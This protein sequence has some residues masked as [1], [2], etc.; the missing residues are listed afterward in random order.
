MP[1]KRMRMYRSCL[2]IVALLGLLP[3]ALPAAEPPSPAATE[4]FE[5]DIRPLLVS[6]CHEC[7]GD[8]KVKGGLHITSRAKLLEGG[9]TGPALVPGKPDESLLI[10]AVRYPSDGLKMPPKGKLPDADIAKLTRWVEM[11]APW[12]ETTAASPSGSGGAFVITEEQRRY[13]AFQPVVRPALPELRNSEARS[14]N[15]IDTFIRAKLAEQGLKPAPPADKRTLIRRATFD[16]TGLPPTPEEV[17]DFLND[18]SPSAFAK[19]VERLLASPAYGERW[20]RHWLDVVRYA[21][22]RDSRGMGGDTDITEAWR[23][24]DW[25]IEAFNDD[26]P[27]DR[28][29]INQIAGD[30]LPP[31]QPGD[32]NVDGLVATGL[33]TI[34]EWGTGDADKEK[35]VTDIVNDQI[36]VVTRSFLGL[37]VGCARCHDHKFDPISQKDYY[38]LAGIFFSTRIL[39]GPGAKTAGS[40]LLRTPLLTKAEQ[41]K[42]D[43]YDKRLKQVEEQLKQATER[44]YARF[45]KELLPRTADYVLAVWD[46]EHR[47]AEQLGQTIAAFAAEKNLHAALLKQWLDVLSNET[48]HPL[49]T[50]VANIGGK[51]GVYG[52]RSA[53]DCPNA[54]INTT[55]AEVSILTFKL[56]PHSVSVHPGPTAG[57]AVAWQSP[58]NGKVSVKGRVL[59]ADPVCGNGIAWKIEHRQGGQAHEVA[60][61]EFPNGGAQPFDQGR[62]GTRLKQIDVHAGDRLELLVLPK[63]DYSCDTTIVELEIAEGDGAR[64]WNLTADTLAAGNANPQLDRQGHPGVWHF[65][66]MGEPANRPKLDPAVGALRQSV[67]AQSDRGTAE[68]SARAFADAFTRVDATNP[69]WITSTEAETLL[70][71]AEREELIRLRRLRDERKRNPPG[72]VPTVL[73]AQDGGVP[74]S[75]FPAIQDVPIHVRGSYTRLGE[76]VPRHFPV[77]LAGEKQPPLPKDASGR[78]ELANWIADA[79]NPVTPRVMANRVWAWHFGEGIVRTPSNFG[80]LGE[81]PTHPELLDYLADEFVKGGWSIKH[82][83]RLIMS[84]QVYQQSSAGDGETLKKDPD[85]R[86]FGHWAPRRLEAEGI[87]DTLLAVAGK[88]DTTPGGMS[89]TDI[90]TPRRTVY[91]R[92]I[93]SDKSGYQALFDAADPETPTEKRNVSTVAPQALFLLNHPFVTEQAKAFARRMMAW[94]V[95]DEKERIKQAYRILY[96]RKAAEKEVALGLGFLAR[97]T[98]SAVT[99]QAW[100]EYAQVLLCANE[101]VYVE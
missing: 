49:T 78:L 7:H 33:L 26:V 4:F 92:T 53:A 46:Y 54:V 75:M 22:S 86:L 68:R 71:A 11:G 95:S 79:T 43:T 63:G 12:P 9:E 87:R 101:L 47:P 64:T 30:R 10:Q 90:S 8:G 16:L 70:P 37:T 66:D 32:L 97:Y 72:P 91:L 24:R 52:W 99:L 34:G 35:M 55:D 2:L 48:Y 23:Y 14:T 94:K 51:P 42:R 17:D 36:D 28:F 39:P 93:R 38:G 20:G 27:Y 77:V 45:A 31:A 56:P 58:I 15:P 84:S 59:D 98:D 19:V 82:L 21:D 96:G 69:F 6:R 13:W 50:P 76:K 88:L 100:E 25:V 74:G 83:H 1:P 44:H 41:A 3:S 89:F 85:N 73:A 29:I 67:L 81:R 40:P 60:G 18:H 61:G 57:V 65:L 80:K 62:G 5:K